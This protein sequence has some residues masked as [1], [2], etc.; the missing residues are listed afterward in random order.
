MKT[1]HLLLVV[2]FFAAF[3]ELHRPTMAA[4][5][6]GFIE[7]FALAA[8]REAVLDELI[9]GTEDFYYFNA[10][11]HQNEGRYGEVEQ[12][13]E[14]WVKRHGETARVWEIRNRQALL[15]YPNQ[16]EKS[17]AYL[18]ERL[19]LRFDHQRQEIGKKQLSQGFNWLC[20]ARCQKT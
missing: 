9:P 16:P 20:A 17:L 2:A 1:T 12:V 18:R 4:E 8:D 10:L 3:T 7:R 14:P 11:H 13:L 5:E 15:L 19:G 6:I